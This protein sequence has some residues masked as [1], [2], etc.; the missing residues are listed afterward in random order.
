MK[1]GNHLFWTASILAALILLWVADNLI[2]GMSGDFPVLNI[3]ALVFAAAIWIL[4][5]LGRFAF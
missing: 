5:L 4:G 2:Y 3:T 1:L